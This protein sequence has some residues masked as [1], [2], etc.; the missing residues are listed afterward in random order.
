M[1]E[2]IMRDTESGKVL[3]QRET[4]AALLFTMHGENATW[5]HR[6]RQTR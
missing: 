4:K 5:Q 6:E 3:Y 1:I 2:V